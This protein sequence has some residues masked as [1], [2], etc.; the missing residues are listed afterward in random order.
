MA[1]WIA[2]VMLLQAGCIHYKPKFDDS[3]EFFSRAQS[4]TRDQVTIRVLGLGAKESLETFGVNLSLQNIL[5]IWIKIENNDSERAYFFLE[6]AMD[7]DYYTASE[8]AFVSQ[9]RLGYRLKRVLPRFLHFVTV[10][11][12]PFDALFTDRANAKLVKEFKARALPYGWIKPGET[13]AGYVFVPFEVGTKV[14]TVDLFMDDPDPKKNMKE[15]EFIIPIPGIRQ[16]YLSRDFNRFFPQQED[17][18]LQTPEQLKAFIE[19]LPCC[20]TNRRGTKNGDPVNLAVVG[21][22]QEVLTAFTAAG[23]DE[24]EIV[25]WGSIWKTIKSFSFKKRYLY[26][27]VSPLYL[28]GRSQDVAFQKARESLD[29]RMHLR[30]WYAPVHY[31]GKPVW[32]GSVSRDIGVRFTRKTWNLMTHKIDPD[33]DEAELYTFSDLIYHKRVRLFERVLGAPVSTEDKPAANLTGDPYYTRG[34]RSVMVL[35]D[36]KQEGFPG[37]IFSAGER[38][39]K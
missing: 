29:Q 25:Y 14:V 1:G 23:W 12:L 36:K 15:F 37:K 26:S 39:G 6:R 28:F 17:Q 33:I 18:F 20:T 32:V 24:T 35:S 9:F 2:G 16:D 27:P 11:L 31:Q 8:A 38:S 34:G 21:T 3:A 5:P 4:E 22:Q 13:R 10:P 19:G 7:P 30:L